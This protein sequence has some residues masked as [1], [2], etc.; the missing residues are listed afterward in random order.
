MNNIYKKILIRRRIQQDN[1][2]F[3]TEGVASGLLCFIFFLS[4]K[5]LAIP[6]FE[7]FKPLN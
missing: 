5:A 6:P 7:S 1:N 4:G 3:E 2:I